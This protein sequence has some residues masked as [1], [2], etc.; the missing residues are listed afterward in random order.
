MRW[1]YDQT[2]SS[3][4][5]EKIISIKNV[6]SLEKEIKNLETKIGDQNVIITEQQKLTINIENIYMKHIIVLH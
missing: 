3:F 2:I 6:E 1:H 4:K 5:A